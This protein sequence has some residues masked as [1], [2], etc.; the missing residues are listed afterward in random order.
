MRS[1]LPTDSARQHRLAAVFALA[2]ATAALLSLSAVFALDMRRARL[3]PALTL[4]TIP[5]ADWP[6]RWLDGAVSAASQQADA[7]SQ[8]LHA[9]LLFGVLAAAVAAINALIGL[10]A[11]ANERR[12]ESA[13]RG[14]VGAAP[15]Q[16]ARSQL[17]H[18]FLNALLGLAAGAP[19]GI[20]VA[21]LLRKVWP[22]AVHGGAL[23]NGWL[24][25][26]A[27]CAIAVAAFAA[28][29]AAGRF[30]RPGWLGD[31]LA[32]E[33]RSLPGWGVEDLRALL[34]VAQLTCAIAL[35][36]VGMLVWSYAHVGA[37]AAAVDDNERYVARVSLH[38]PDRSAAIMRVRNALRSQTG[39][40]AES[41]ASPG[42][43]L[44]IGK[45]D[46]VISE[47]GQCVRALMLT[48]FF[49][50]ETQSHVVGSHFFRA[51]GIPVRR[52]VE[53]TG[54]IGEAD[55][56]V[57]NETFARLAFDDPNPI[58][59]HIV[60]GGVSGRRYEVIGIVA[61][62][63]TVGLQ[64][65]EPDAGAVTGNRPLSH[66]PAVY[67]SARAH[68][69]GT[70]DIIARASSRPNLAGLSFVPLA[71]VFAQARAPQQWFGRV[72]LV[73][74]ML[75]CGAALIGSFI[76]TMLNVQSRRTEIALRRA[77]G[78]RRRAIWLLVYEAVLAMVLR[79][80]IAGVIVS[81]ALSRAVEPFVPGLPLFNWPIALTVC[82]IFALISAL[83]TLLPV[84]AALAITPAQAE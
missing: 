30:H 5:D 71:Q 60:V 15:A 33:A 21:V 81:I 38:E 63:E 19:L 34:T 28:R 14:L 58:G 43:L 51:A 27:F 66:A 16:L 80:A 56:V 22:G 41:I 49:P 52:G 17:G 12:Y 76:T 39:V 84:R 3:A 32:P 50:V 42:T 18:G 46:K 70:F 1:V 40:Q 62:V 9:I 77:L 68:P 54:G 55:D 36:I 67:F 10:L 24:L 11:H 44:G 25:L 64:L 82:C 26:A 78:A 73:L 48:P 47:C 45:V 59:K 13:L 53:F 20:I 29:S 8:W 69:P 7:A 6:M 35:A 72:V 37:S 61:D 79:G 31:A 2:L 4:D 57:I 65:L 74:G 23:L 83:A 75:L